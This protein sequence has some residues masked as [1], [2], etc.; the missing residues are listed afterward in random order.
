MENIEMWEKFITLQ[1]G[2]EIHL[3]PQGG[4]LYAEHTPYPISRKQA[5]FLLQCDGVHKIKDIIPTLWNENFEDFDFLLFLARMISKERLKFLDKP[6]YSPLKITGSKSAYIPPHLSIEVTAECNLRCRHC[7]RD[8]GPQQIERMPTSSLLDILQRLV[9]NGLRAV[10]ITGGEPFKHPDIITILSFCE[11]NFEL[12]GVLTNGTILN[13][14]I[15]SKLRSMGDHVFLSI[16]L[17][18]ST[19]E[20]HDPRRGCISAFERTVRNI[21]L[22]S[23]AGVKTRVSMCVDE[24]NF[25]DVENTL[26]L[27]QKL[28][29]LAFTYSPILPFGR[30]KNSAQHGWRL[31]A[32]EVMKLE[33]ELAERYKGFLTSYTKEMACDLDNDEN[34]GAGYRTYAMD[35]LGNVRPC[36]TFGTDEL[37]IGNLVKQGI[38]E[39]FSHPVTMAMEKISLPSEKICGDCRFSLFC[40]YCPLRG[41]Y[42]SQRVPNCSWIH[43]PAVQEVL[44]FWNPLH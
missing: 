18:G 27:A 22:L 9:D 4:V 16:S 36:V 1:Q 37:I 2:N 38:E 41:F 19:S 35:P 44:N 28:G 42:G 13:E 32:R 11:E 25:A 40:R 33:I 26:L 31:D 10:E 23:K 15:I 39:V 43:L 7:Y 21:E 30:G 17:D 3:N 5:D 12:T 14:E 24:G 34:C 20:I 6:S 29:A 8:S